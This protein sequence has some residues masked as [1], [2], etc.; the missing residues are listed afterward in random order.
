MKHNL[1]HFSEFMDD[2]YSRLPAEM[3]AEEPFLKLASRKGEDAASDSIQNTVR[4]IIACA[5]ASAPSELVGD[6]DHYCRMIIETYSND[7]LKT[8]T[9]SKYGAGACDYIV[10][11]FR[12]YLYQNQGK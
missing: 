9:D 10:E 4:E 11:A 8:I 2:W 3:R 7:Y 12:H 5:H 6:D 1:E